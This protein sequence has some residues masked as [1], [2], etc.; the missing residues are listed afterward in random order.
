[1]GDKTLKRLAWIDA[2]RGY[3]IIGVMMGHLHLL[4]PPAPVQL[5]FLASGI[6]LMYSRES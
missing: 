4:G 1:M 2:L 3:A 5:F 6:A